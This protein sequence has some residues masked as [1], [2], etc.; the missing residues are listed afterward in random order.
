MEPRSYKAKSFKLSQLKG[1]SDKTL[2]MHFGLYE[3]YVKNTNLLTQQLFEITQQ[4]KALATRG[5]KGKLNL[6]AQNL[7]LFIQLAEGVDDETWIYHLENGDYSRWLRD[8][9]KDDA[10]AQEVER[11]E[12][13]P[14]VT[15]NEGQRLIRAMVEK[16][17][18]LP[19]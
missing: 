13:L 1:I 5:P 14:K 6:R 3:G 19:A 12:K 11:I 18:T 15:P 17:Y 10:L 7:I 9:I 2:E 8:V 4:R 16:H